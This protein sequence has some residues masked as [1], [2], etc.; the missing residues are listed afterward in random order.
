MADCKTRGCEE[1]LSLAAVD[2]YSYAP[3][4][5]EIGLSNP[6]LLALLL[7]DRSPFFSSKFSLGLLSP[8]MHP[9]IVG[10]FFGLAFLE[11]SFTTLF[12]AN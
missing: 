4:R 9:P 5:F 3:P 6:L 11:R 10:F 1:L 12:V 7:D 8:E 2:D